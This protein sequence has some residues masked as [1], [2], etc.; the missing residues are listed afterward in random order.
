MDILLT[1][2]LSLFMDSYCVP[3]TL[4]YVTFS[5]QKSTKGQCLFILRPLSRFTPGKSEAQRGGVT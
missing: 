5:P 1:T 3:E 4:T 2:Q